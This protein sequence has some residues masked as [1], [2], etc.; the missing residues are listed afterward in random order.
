MAAVELFVS[1]FMRPVVAQVGSL[2]ILLLHVLSLEKML[3]KDYFTTAVGN[4][5]GRFGKRSTRENAT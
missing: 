1:K 4:S 2:I 5:S 3:A